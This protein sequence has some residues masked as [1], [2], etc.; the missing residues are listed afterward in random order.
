MYRGLGHSLGRATDRADD[1]LRPI[2]TRP[3]ADFA[4]WLDHHRSG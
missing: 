3:M 4:H 1:D 2:T